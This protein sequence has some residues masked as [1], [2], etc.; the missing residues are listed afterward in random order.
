M[1]WTVPNVR[2][3]SG[4]EVPTINPRV[5]LLADNVLQ[6]LPDPF[7]RP[8]A[9]ARRKRTS[10]PKFFRLENR[11]ENEYIRGLGRGQIAPQ[12]DC[13]NRSRQHRR[14]SAD[15]RLVRPWSE[16]CAE[17]EVGCCGSAGTGRRWLQ[18]R[19]GGFSMRCWSEQSAGTDYF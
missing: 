2:R 12:R 15:G 7:P 13:R 19:E 5:I 4:Y 16:D 9:V 3:G 14:G 6:T 11:C 10:R 18:R 1:I 17:E 8:R